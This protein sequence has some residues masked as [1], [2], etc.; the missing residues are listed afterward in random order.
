MYCTV[1]TQQAQLRREYSLYRA[2]CTIYIYLCSPL[3]A[4]VL[5]TRTP[6]HVAVQCT[7]EYHVTSIC[8]AM[9][10]LQQA[11]DS[12]THRQSAQR[13]QS[14]AERVGR[15]IARHRPPS[16]TTTGSTVLQ[17]C[18]CTGTPRSDYSRA[19]L[20]QIWQL[21]AGRGQALDRSFLQRPPPILRLQSRTGG[22]CRYLPGLATTAH[23][24]AR[25]SAEASSRIRTRWTACTRRRPSPSPIAGVSLSSLAHAERPHLFLPL[26]HHAAVELERGSR[27]EPEHGQVSPARRRYWLR[28]LPSQQE[29]TRRR[30]LHRIP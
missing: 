25:R 28:S 27:P 21:R 8:P 29:A 15:A 18:T 13:A 17:Y 9:C 6:L 3:C 2:P 19:A 4:C 1:R 22:E 30:N 11:A 14:R 23:G 12:N 16:P 24:R 26:H 7:L 5:R 20:C 10:S